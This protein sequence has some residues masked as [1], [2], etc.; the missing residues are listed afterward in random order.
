MSKSSHCW[1]GRTCS[2]QDMGLSL[3]FSPHQT[4]TSSWRHARENGDEE[5]L[6][7]SIEAATSLYPQ[8]WAASLIT[9]EHQSNGTGQK[10]GRSQPSLQWP[11]EHE[12]DR[13]LQ[14]WAG[15]DSMKNRKTAWACRRESAV[16]G[17]TELGSQSRRGTSRGVLQVLPWPGGRLLQTSA[18]S[19]ET[20]AG[21]TQTWLGLRGSWLGV[22]L[23]SNGI[24]LL[25]VLGH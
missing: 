9:V 6:G 12:T 5:R 10:Q 8:K 13:H 19:W 2:G 4:L 1:S 20:V 3:W 17:E 7:K 15:S 22:G 14:Q 18:S 24:S 11:W 16:P 21:E 23:E 25:I